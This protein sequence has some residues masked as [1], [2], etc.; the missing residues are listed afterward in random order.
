LGE[1]RE[2]KP[3]KPTAT[4]WPSSEE[5]FGDESYRHL[6]ESLQDFA[7]YLLD[8]HGRIRSWNA[9]AEKIY[10]YNAEEVIGKPHGTFLGAAEIECGLPEQELQRAATKGRLEGEGWCVRKDGSRFSCTWTL[11]ALRDKDG[12][13]SGFSKIVRD[14][15]EM[16]AAEGQIRRLNGELE[17]R[18]A[19]RTAQLEAANRELEA[20]SYSVS[21]DLRAP[22][23]HIGG[24]VEILQHSALEQLEPEGQEYLRIIAES[25][26]QMTRLIDALLA[27][28][29]MGRAAMHRTRLNMT[30][31]IGA[32]L[33]DLR[34]DIYSRNIEWVIGELPEVFADESLIRQVLLNLV[35]NALK[36]SR[37]RQ[38]A[39]IEVG[40][41][42]TAQETI[43]FVRDNGIG[44]D[45]RWA[46]KLFGVFQRLHAAPEFEGTG[47]GLANVRRIIQRH[48]GRTWAEAAPDCGATFYFSLPKAE[49]AELS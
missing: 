25:A 33:H 43:F 49:I 45:M 37:P 40:A 4:K 47:I 11:T 18:V 21:H 16:K 26:R 48:G 3:R 46:D 17:E 34:H 19:R 24:F 6:V 44:F 28:S 36:Y 5:N 35:S 22:L 42:A 10:G 8:P 39:R 32:T 38:A 29:R 31:L 14:V 41:T 1:E 9:G 23:R 13:L 15:T 7:V 2:A 12:R 20:F 27:F 30:N